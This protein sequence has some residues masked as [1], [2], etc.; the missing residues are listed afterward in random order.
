MFYIYESQNSMWTWMSRPFL[1]I[2]VWD[3]PSLFLETYNHFKISIISLQSANTLLTNYGVA[4][5]TSLYIYRRNRTVI[6]VKISALSSEDATKL[7]FSN[8]L[9]QYPGQILTRIDSR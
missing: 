6:S 8:S 1:Q 7:F 3:K 9:P 5:V 2:R 4:N